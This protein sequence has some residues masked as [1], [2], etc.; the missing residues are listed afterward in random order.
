MLQLGRFGSHGN[1]WRRVVTLIAAVRA[2]MMILWRAEKEKERRAAG[3]AP[4]FSLVSGTPTTNN[5]SRWPNGER[6]L[7]K[8]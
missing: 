1:G 5:D 7:I 3:L 2:P 8:S 6:P 4:F